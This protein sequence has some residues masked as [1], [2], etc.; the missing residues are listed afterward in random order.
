MPD[1][2]PA[3]PSPTPPPRKQPV[4][5]V[6]PPAPAGPAAEGG[7]RPAIVT[8]RALAN[9]YIPGATPLAKDRCRVGFWNVTGRDV[10][11]TVGGK[12][13]PLAKDRSLTLDLERQ[14]TW[15]IDQ[16]P[17]HVERIPDVQSTHE[18]VLRE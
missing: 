2:I 8:T 6:R 18:V 15:Q 11:L 9:G 13:W 12:A 17:Q 14:F 3:P 7:T 10:T 4:K 5:D 1:P 16:E